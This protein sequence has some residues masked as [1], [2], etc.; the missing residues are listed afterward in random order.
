MAIRQ[1]KFAS[2]PHSYKFY[3]HR[4]IIPP[5]RLMDAAP[6]GGPEKGGA[7]RGAGA[8]AKEMQ[9]GRLVWAS[10]SRGW[11]QTYDPIGKSNIRRMPHRDI[12]SL[13]CILLTITFSGCCLHF[14]VLFRPL[15]YALTIGKISI[16]SAV[17]ARGING[18]KTELPSNRTNNRIWRVF[19]GSGSKLNL[20]RIINLR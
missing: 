12:Y 20:R 16:F 3:A 6:P 2:S 13:L 18:L 10:E 14:R 8:S 17:K 1:C 5:V 9:G 19:M 4:Y 15:T 11:L 7:G